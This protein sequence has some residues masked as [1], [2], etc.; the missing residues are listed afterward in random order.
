MIRRIS[1]QMTVH[2]ISVRTMIGEDA[3]LVTARA[4]VRFPHRAVNPHASSLQD[5][6][7]IV[8]MLKFMLLVEISVC[9]YRLK[10]TFV[11]GG[12]IFSRAAGQ[13]TQTCLA[14]TLPARETID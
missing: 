8:R 4:K 1:S 14:G 7:S 10:S 6:R 2:S 12:V 11:A 13:I 9:C 3:M 5:H